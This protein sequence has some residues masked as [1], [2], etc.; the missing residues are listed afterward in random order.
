MVIYMAGS[1][2]EIYGTKEPTAEI[3]KVDDGKIKI[4]SIKEGTKVKITDFG[5][6]ILIQRV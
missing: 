5:N 4:P 1:V 6:S 2:F 3:Q